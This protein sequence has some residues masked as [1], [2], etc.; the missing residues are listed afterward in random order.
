MTHY[1]ADSAAAWQESW[2]LQQEAFLPDREHR[3]TTMLDAVGAVTDDAPPRVL[4]LAG[5]TGTISLRTLARFPG[6]EVTVV[7]QDP[8]LLAL[9]TASLGDRA[10]IIA[11]DLGDPSWTAALPHRRY[12]AVLTATALHWLPP[13]RLTTLYGEILQVLRPGGVFANADH[14]PD[15]GLPG[16]TKRLMTRADTRR[17]TRYATGAA[18]SWPGWWSKVA[19]DPQLAPLFAEREKIYPAAHGAAEWTPPAAW[20]LDALRAAGFTETGLL[21]RGAADATVAAV[22]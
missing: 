5:G 8:V 10:T 9:A 11:A 20:H 18:L 19:A 12:D 3:F 21:W 2:N 14:M 7:D 13:E 17:E 15:E 1:L 16:L 22:R 6:A 4:D